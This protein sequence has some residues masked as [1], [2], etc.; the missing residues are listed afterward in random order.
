VNDCNGSEVK[1][2]DAEKGTITFG[3]KV[4]AEVAGKTWTVAKEATVN[5]DGK[6][7]KLSELPAGAFVNLVFCVD[8]KTIRH[9][10][11]QG[12]QVRS[13]EAA[14][15]KAV[16]ARKGTITFDDKAPAAVAGKTFAVARDAR[17][18]IDGKRAQLA[19]LP[20]GALLCLGLSVDRKTILYCTAQGPQ[21]R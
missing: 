7:S 13:H 18:E 8:R 5:I 6:Q 12:P 2:V 21:I 9:I 14:P 15:V 16:D 10:Q 20:A 19:D 3:D 4:R 11:A 17:I 1:A